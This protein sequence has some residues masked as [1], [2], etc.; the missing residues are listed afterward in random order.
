MSVDANIAYSLSRE[1][2]VGAELCKMALERSKNDIQAAIRCLERWNC[3]KKGQ[4]AQTSFGLVCSYFEREHNAA[5]IVQV[6]CSDELF[7]KTREFYELTGL[8]TTEIVNHTH[9]YTAEY[10]VADLEKRHNCKINVKSFRFEKTGDFS[11]LTTYNHRD[12]TGV[13]IETE[14]LNKEA[15]ENKQF[16]LFSFDCAL[17]ITAFNPIAISKT[18]IPIDLKFEMQA[19]IEKQLARE[20]K[21]MRYWAIAAEGKLNKWAEQ[22]SLLTQ[23]FIK[24]DKDTV[25]DIKNKISEKIGSEITIKRFARFTVGS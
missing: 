4:S 14:V 24:S 18:D 21:D 9:P 5:A 17:H 20:G 7:S 23:I 12:T 1:T 25:E 8:I 6:N 22:R 13:I 19:N 3:Y 10:Q 16:K 11:L 15:F 2:G